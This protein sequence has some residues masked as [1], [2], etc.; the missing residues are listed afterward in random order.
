MALTVDLTDE[1]LCPFIQQETLP[2]ADTRFE[3]SHDGGHAPAAE[4]TLSQS[5]ESLQTGDSRASVTLRT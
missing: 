3:R 2:S 5:S 1:R 4:L